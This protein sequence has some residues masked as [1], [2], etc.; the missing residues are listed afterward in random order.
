M[1]TIGILL[2]FLVPLAAASS[3]FEVSEQAKHSVASGKLYAQYQYTV[4]NINA[5]DICSFS[6]N[7]DADES[8]LLK[9]V[10]VTTPPPWPEE[11]LSLSGTSSNQWV[12][13][14]EGL[15]DTPYYGVSWYA[16]MEK[17]VR[18]C[19]RPGQ[20]ATFSF[21]APQA[22]PYFSR[23]YAWV[24]GNKVAVNVL[25]K[26]PPSLHIYLSDNDPQ[27]RWRDRATLRVRVE[28]KDNLDPNPQVQLERITM[29]RRVLPGQVVQASPTP[30]RDGDVITLQRIPLAEYQL[31]FSAMDASN[32][33]ASFVRKVQI[34]LLGQGVLIM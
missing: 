18:D 13:E 19:L 2:F 32:N 8:T 21:T 20:Q 12:F 33:R 17:D 11:W 6:L 22:K 1:K 27:L 25:D 14:A 7:D 9:P 3:L 28:V 29:T 24:N 4:K 10:L 34:K 16:S 31:T 23:G 5:E 26:T 15:E 30:V